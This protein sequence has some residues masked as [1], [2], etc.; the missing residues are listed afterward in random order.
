MDAATLPDDDE[1]EMAPA[2]N[3]VDLSQPLSQAGLGGAGLTE[4]LANIAAAAAAPAGGG[5]ME[6]CGL[7]RRRLEDL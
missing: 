1:E 5:T 4:R 7:T 6:F 3:N 2:A